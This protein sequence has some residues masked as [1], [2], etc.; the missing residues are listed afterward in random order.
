MDGDEKADDSEHSDAHPLSPSSLSSF[1]SSPLLLLFKSSSSSNLFP[2]PPLSFD[3]CACACVD[4]L[5]ASLDGKRHGDAVE[6]HAS[7]C[8]AFAAGCFEFLPPTRQ[9]EDKEEA[10]WCPFITRTPVSS[11]SPVSPDASRPGVFE[12]GISEI[13][14]CLDLCALSIS[15]ATSSG[16]ATPSDTHSDDSPGSTFRDDD[17]G[18]NEHSALSDANE[19][20]G[21]AGW[22]G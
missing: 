5:D 18:E 20:K 16:G 11:V 14:Q 15:A 1:S 7:G 12:C 10:G 17:I 4:S 8:T 13:V 19:K 21:D 2:F 9:L 3:A 22:K 6:E